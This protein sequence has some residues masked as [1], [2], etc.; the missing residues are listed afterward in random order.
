MK[1]G[2]ETKKKE[3]RKEN[4]KFQSSVIKNLTD[5]VPFCNARSVF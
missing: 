5:F 4:H 1:K 3:D 2:E